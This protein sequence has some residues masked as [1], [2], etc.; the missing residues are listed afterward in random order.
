MVLPATPVQQDSSY[1]QTH[2]QLVPRVLP[3]A[4]TVVLMVQLV[5]PVLLGFTLMLMLVLL[6]RSR[7]VLNARV[8]RYVLS[9]ILG[10]IL[11]V[12]IVARLA[13]TGYPIALLARITVHVPPAEQVSSS[14]GEPVLHVDLQ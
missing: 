8:Q 12:E 10:S 9:V 6:A 7:N 1:L 5:T 3:N 14:M 2:V 13:Q 4:L 11:I